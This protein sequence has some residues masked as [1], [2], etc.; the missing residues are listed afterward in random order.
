MNG[1]VGERLGEIFKPPDEGVPDVP[2]RMVPMPPTR[3]E[4]VARAAVGSQL[5]TGKATPEPVIPTE[6][7]DRVRALLRQRHYESAAAYAEIALNSLGIEV[8]GGQVEGSEAQE[9]AD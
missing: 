4:P 1:P 3:G 7:G 9:P 2:K 6:V 5:P 8:P